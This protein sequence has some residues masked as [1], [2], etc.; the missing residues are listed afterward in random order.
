[1]EYKMR[2]ALRLVDARSRS[3][4]DGDFKGLPAHEVWLIGLSQTWCCTRPSTARDASKCPE[5]RS[6][7]DTRCDVSC[8]L[9]QDGR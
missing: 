2:Q 4:N 9:L 7:V 1:M 6:D 5:A 3:G 8:M